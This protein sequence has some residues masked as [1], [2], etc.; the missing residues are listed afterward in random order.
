MK[1]GVV[2]GTFDH[3]HPGHEWFLLQASKQCNHL[4]VIVAHDADVEKRK[5]RMPSQPLAKRIKNV[6]LFLPLATVCA[7]DTRERQWSVL[8]HEHIDVC[9]IGYDQTGL[10]NAIEEFQQQHQQPFAIIQLGSYFPEKYKT[11]LYV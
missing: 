2:F 7:G 5:G 9:V 1:R 4:T 10:R 11:S 6:Q 3:F 8:N